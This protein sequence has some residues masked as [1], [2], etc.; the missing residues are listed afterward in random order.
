MP[1]ELTVTVIGLVTM[2]FGDCVLSSTDTLNV[3]AAAG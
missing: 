2:E 3:Y 1:T